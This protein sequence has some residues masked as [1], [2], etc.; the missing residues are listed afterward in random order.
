MKKQTIHQRSSNVFCM[1]INILLICLSYGFTGTNFIIASI[2]GSHHPYNK[3][4]IMLGIVMLCMVPISCFDKRK[5]MRGK[6]SATASCMIHF[7]LSIGIAY[8]YESWQIM[9]LYA[10]EVVISMSFLIKHIWSKKR[11]KKS[12]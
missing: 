3:I 12:I 10:V 1:Q 6:F 8:M 2:F 4:S 11:N 9:I 7:V 5:E